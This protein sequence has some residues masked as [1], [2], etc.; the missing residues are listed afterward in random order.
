MIDRQTTKCFFPIKARN[1]KNKI[2][3]KR[4]RYFGSYEYQEPLIIIII[5][6]SIFNFKGNKS[7]QNISV[8]KNLNV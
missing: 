3:V 4:I 7:I 8:Y 6:R 5:M 1:P 2:Y